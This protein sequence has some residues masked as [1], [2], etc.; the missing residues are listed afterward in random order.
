MELLI[1]LSLITI[2]VA[3]TCSTSWHLSD[4]P[5]LNHSR[6]AWRTKTGLPCG[7]TREAQPKIRAY[8]AVNKKVYIKATS[9]SQTWAGTSKK[10]YLRNCSKESGKS[11]QG[12]RLVSRHDGAARVGRWTSG[13]FKFLIT[14]SNASVLQKSYHQKPCPI[15]LPSNTWI[16]SVFQGN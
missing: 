11:G 16:S 12:Q 4:R 5:H 3:F 10:D 6:T 1:S 15:K 7:P 8:L 2:I 13:S 9:F 14:T